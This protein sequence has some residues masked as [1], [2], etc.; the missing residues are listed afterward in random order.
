MIKEVIRV[1]NMFDSIMWALFKLNLLL[2]G[3]IIVL[4]IALGG[5]GSDD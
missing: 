2:L 1:I 5:G 4:K 3:N